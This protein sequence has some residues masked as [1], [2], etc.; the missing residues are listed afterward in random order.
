MVLSKG[1][2]GNTLR[3]LYYAGTGSAIDEARQP[4]HRYLHGIL[5]ECIASV[6]GPNEHR[7]LPSNMHSSRGTAYAAPV[8]LASDRIPT[9]KLI[10][11]FNDQ[12]DTTWRFNPTHLLYIFHD[13]SRTSRRT[14]DQCFERQAQRYLRNRRVRMDADSARNNS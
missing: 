5:P 11:T 13:S 8:R 9:F 7:V 14:F 2:S 4:E 1:Y 12:S 10:V 6:S 3:A